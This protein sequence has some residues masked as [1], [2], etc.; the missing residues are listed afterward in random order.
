ML[1]AALR[2]GHTE[3]YEEVGCGLVYA[4]TLT[5]FVIYLLVCGVQIVVF[6]W[7]VIYVTER[8]ED[9]FE[10]DMPEEI[11]LLK[12][13]VADNTMLDMSIPSNSALIMKCYR[14]HSVAYTQVVMVSVWIMRM[15]NDVTAAFF[16]VYASFKMKV[17]DSTEMEYQADGIT[18]VHRVTLHFKWF[19]LLVVQIPRTAIALAFGYSGAKF[20]MFASSLG[21][22]I[23]KAVGMAFCLSFDSF[24]FTALASQAFVQEVKVT[25]LVYKLSH[26]KRLGYHWS[27]YGSTWVRLIVVLT[28]AWLFTRVLYNDVASLRWACNAYEERFQQVPSLAVTWVNTTCEN[29][30]F[31][32]YFGHVF[33]Y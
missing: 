6:L 26:H 9:P 5:T 29:C 19:S 12:Q 10:V 22:L 3:R 31:H 14:D 27:F 28:L 25:K 8:R 23:M 18:M 24:M 32:D 11:A 13:A 16:A 30:G 33:M 4:S 2:F 1:R 21:T 17:C 7:F 15:G 20:L